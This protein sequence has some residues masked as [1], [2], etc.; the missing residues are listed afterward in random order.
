MNF[1]FRAKS[2]HLVGSNR[3]L[4]TNFLYDYRQRH[5]VYHFESDHLFFLEISQLK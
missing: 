1:D 2:D 5:K 4:E 3:A